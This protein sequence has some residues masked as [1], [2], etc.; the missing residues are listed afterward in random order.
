MTTVRV[1]GLAVVVLFII[2]VEIVEVALLRSPLGY[3]KKRR[4]V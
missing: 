2:E 4:K 3:K 1:H